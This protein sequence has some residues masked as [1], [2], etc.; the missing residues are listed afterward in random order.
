MISGAGDGG[1]TKKWFSHQQCHGGCQETL[2]STGTNRGE[3][4]VSGVVVG[5]VFV[6]LPN[7]ELE[8]FFSLFQKHN[9][10]LQLIHKNTPN[11]HKTQ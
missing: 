1:F 7:N 4:C 11:V 9:L 5:F 6:L 10:Y 8:S 2:F 3:F